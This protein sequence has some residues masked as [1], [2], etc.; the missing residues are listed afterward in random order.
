M[1]NGL[2]LFSGIGGLTLA[3][4]EWARPVA[5]VENDHFTQ[6]VLVARMRDKQLPTAP[7]WDDVTTLHASSLPT[8][9]II[10]GGF[11]CQDISTANRNGQGLEG[12]RSG[13]FGEIVR[14]ASET[15]AKYIFLENVAAIRTRGLDT[16]AEQLTTIGY[17]MRWCTLSAREVGACHQRSRWWCLA[18]RRDVNGN[19]ARILS[20]SRKVQGVR[21]KSAELEDLPGVDSAI[22]QRN[23][24]ERPPHCWG[25]HQ[26]RVRGGIDDVPNRMDRL[27]ALGNSV[28]PLCA[29]VAFE[30]LLT[31]AAQIKLH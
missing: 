9:D 17:D 25:E 27:K 13:L 30:I 19:P 5:Y 3:L 18:R 11:P 16:V 15:G 20:T 10:Y 24:Q 6:A 12:K 31:G 1:L 29:K 14:L 22:V 8:I 28:V 23:P 2:D 4:Q 7:I 21:T 26:P